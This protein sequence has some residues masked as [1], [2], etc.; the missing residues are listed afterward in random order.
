MK[1]WHFSEPEIFRIPSGMG[2]LVKSRTLCL[3]LMAT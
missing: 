1:N 2:L 3:I